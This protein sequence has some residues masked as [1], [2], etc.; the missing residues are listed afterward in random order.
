MKLV[1]FRSLVYATTPLEVYIDFEEFLF[2]ASW[3]AFVFAAAAP[4][5]PGVL[6]WNFSEIVMKR[7]RAAMIVTWI[8]AQWN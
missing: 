2:I 5:T 4:D 8:E 1:P 6:G 7:T 3:S